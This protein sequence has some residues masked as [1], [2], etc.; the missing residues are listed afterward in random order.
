MSSKHHYYVGPYVETRCARVQEPRTRRT[1][2]N[3]LCAVSKGSHHGNFCAV[4]G[5]P[6]GDVAY[7]VEV[8]AVSAPDLCQQIREA[9]MNKDVADGVHAWLPNAGR[10]QP[11]RFRLGGEDGQA[12]AT[13]ILPTQ[14]FR[15]REWL[16]GA[17]SAEIEAMRVAYGAENVTIRWGIVWMWM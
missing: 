1:C 15:E 11:R 4:C 6:V 13:P 2:T 17:F 12:G 5:A 9:L 16:G 8:D 10:S 3:A 14:H 7:S